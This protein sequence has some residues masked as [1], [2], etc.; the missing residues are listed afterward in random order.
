MWGENW[1]HFHWGSPVNM[2]ALGPVGFLIL[3]CLLGVSGVLLLR[4]GRKTAGALAAFLVL[5]PFT[6]FATTVPFIFTNGTVADATQVNANFTALT[7][8]IGSNNG[9]ASSAFDNGTT[10]WVFASSPD[11]TAPRNLTC[12]VTVEAVGT[13]ATTVTDIQFTPA[14]Q[15]GS[16]QTRGAGGNLFINTGSNNGGDNNLSTTFT[17]IFSVTSGQ[18]VTFGGWFSLIQTGVHFTPEVTSVYYCL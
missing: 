17:Q 1:G 5:V 2:P 12:I 6:A 18:V 14:I 15:V 10:P 16:T 11:F 9:F 8:I 13:A 3:G 4:S 7:P